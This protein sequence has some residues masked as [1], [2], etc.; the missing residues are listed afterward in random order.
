MFDKC[1]LLYVQSW[2]ANGGRKDCPKHVEWYSE[3]NFDTFVHLLGFTTEILWNKL[4]VI[5]IDNRY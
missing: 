4:N 3:T 2:T 5:Q 1:L